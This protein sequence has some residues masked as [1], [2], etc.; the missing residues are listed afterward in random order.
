MLL[1]FKLNSTPIHAF[2]SC[3]NHHRQAYSL[4]TQDTNKDT[5]PFFPRHKSHIFH[6]LSTHTQCLKI[7]RIS[8]MNPELFMSLIVTPD[9]VRDILIHMRDR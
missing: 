5:D 3:L 6:S 7:T 4:F 2:V 8:I 1:P 9:R